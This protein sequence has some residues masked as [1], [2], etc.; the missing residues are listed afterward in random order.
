MTVVIFRVLLRSRRPLEGKNT[1]SY[2]R[3]VKTWAAWLLSNKSSLWESLWN[4][5]IWLNKWSSGLCGRAVLEYLLLK[6]V[7]QQVKFTNCT[8]WSCQQ[9]ASVLCVQGSAPT[10]SLKTTLVF[11]SLSDISHQSLE[12]CREEEPCWWVRA[13]CF[14]HCPLRDSPLASSKASVSPPKN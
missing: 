1:I 14:T 8:S 3:T 4:H 5:F 13:F 9:R 7:I 12:R 11:I 2:T 6:P 10:Q